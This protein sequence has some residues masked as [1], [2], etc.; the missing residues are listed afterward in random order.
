MRG[1]ESENRRNGRMQSMDDDLSNTIA[2]LLAQREV[3]DSMED[4]S[5]R[6]R[7][8]VQ[9]IGKQVAAHS[10]DLDHTGKQNVGRLVREAMARRGWK[11]ARKARVAPGCFFSWGAVYTPVG[12]A[13]PGAGAGAVRMAKLREMLGQLEGELPSVDEFLASRKA[14]WGQ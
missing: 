3:V 5:R 14:M 10:P 13:S 4:L 1:N 9:A 7:P 8:A 2:N 12:G 11:P 6:G